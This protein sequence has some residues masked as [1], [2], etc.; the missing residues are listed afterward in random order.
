MEKVLSEQ[1]D[2]H[3]FLERKLIMPIKENVQ[4]RQSYRKRSLSWTDE[5]GKCK[6]LV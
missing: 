1:K 4:L 5:N 3:D 2:I 6:M